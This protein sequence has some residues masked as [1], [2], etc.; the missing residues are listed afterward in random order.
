MSSGDVSDSAKTTSQTVRGSGARARKP[1]HAGQAAG[2]PPLEMR[3]AAQVPP[4][5]DTH[6]SPAATAQNRPSSSRQLGQFGL[7]SRL[8]LCGNVSRGDGVG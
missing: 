4:A 2:Q 6:V 1:G 3:V 7:N 5:A 8:S